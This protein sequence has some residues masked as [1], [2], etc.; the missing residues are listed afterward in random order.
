[1]N[2]KEDSQMDQRTTIHIRPCFLRIH[3]GLPVM[4][5]KM[6]IEIFMILLKKLPVK[7]GGGG[8]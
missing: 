5:C 6:E 2:L 1:M 3:I 8:L 7:R 4:A